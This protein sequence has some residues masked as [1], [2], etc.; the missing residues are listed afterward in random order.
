MCLPGCVL[1][2]TGTINYTL[3]LCDISELR[4]TLVLR[5]GH[6]RGLLYSLLRFR[7]NF[8]ILIFLRVPAQT[9]S[10]APIST[11]PRHRLTVCKTYYDFLQSHFVTTVE[12]PMVTMSSQIVLELPVNIIIELR[13]CQTLNPKRNGVCLFITSFEFKKYTVLPA[14]Q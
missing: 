14:K 8:E 10:L 13:V 11:C 1:P 7:K 5:F 12:S 6:K 4:C 2:W 3:V 9:P